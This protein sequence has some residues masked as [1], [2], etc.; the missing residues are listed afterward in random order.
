[1]Q[2]LDQVGL[3]I[4]CWGNI[5]FISNPICDVTG[6][7]LPF[8]ALAEGTEAA[9]SLEALHNPPE[10]IKARIAVKFDDNSRKLIHKLKYQDQHHIAPQMA[11]MMVRA[12]TDLLEDVD[13]SIICPVP[14]HH[15]RYVTRRFNQAD[16]LA[17]EISKLSGIDYAPKLIKR[18]LSTKTQVGLT[19]KERQSNVRNAFTIT[20]KFK[21]TA[22][23]K[24]IILVD[25]VITT[26]AT[27]DEIAKNLTKAGLGPVYI[28]AFAKVIRTKV[29]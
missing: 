15:W 20:E 28:M 17:K 19:R 3:C 2:V 5:K 26:G 12:A 23:N 13:N 8:N 29:I 1:M 24:A 9:L 25:D 21:E 16:L 7:P 14:L 4:D 11:K 27:V 22:K 18:K 6:T 10:Y